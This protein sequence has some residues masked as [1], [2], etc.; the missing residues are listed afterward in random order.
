[1][2]GEET[3]YKDDVSMMGADNSAMMIAGT[4]L[5]T[6][7][8]VSWLPPRGTLVS[9]AQYRQPILDHLKIITIQQLQPYF[10]DANSHYMSLFLLTSCVEL[11]LYREQRHAS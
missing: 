8:I 1:M 10:E 2:G 3:K 6:H 11:K 9:G 5:V 4:E 7:G